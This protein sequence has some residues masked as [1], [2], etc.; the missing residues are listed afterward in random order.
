MIRFFNHLSFMHSE[1]FI[2]EYLVSEC[3]GIA[4]FL[5]C[6]NF[7][8]Y[9]L[10]TLCIS[11]ALMVSVHFQNKGTLSSKIINKT[12]KYYDHFQNAC[13][14]LCSEEIHSTCMYVLL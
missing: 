4:N 1:D 8:K 2:M 9:V 14:L 3:N 12:P 10:Q 5:S 11:K 7:L 13:M 6:L